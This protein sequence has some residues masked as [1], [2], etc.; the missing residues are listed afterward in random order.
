MTQTDPK[1]NKDLSRIHIMKK[2]LGYDDDFYRTLLQGITGK[3]SAKDMDYKERW[4]VMCEMARLLNGGKAPSGGAKGR[5]PGEPPGWAA[6][7]APL[8]GKIKALLADAKR[9]WAYVHAMA[10]RMFGRDLVQFCDT[11]QLWRIVAA[12]E[13]DKR[14]REDRAAKAEAL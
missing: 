1:R 6:D 7:K 9:P 14:R 3:S 12:L 11:D 2:D 4:R 13:K 10:K 5:F 8:G